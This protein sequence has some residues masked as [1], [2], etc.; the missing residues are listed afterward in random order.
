MSNAETKF[1]KS[2]YNI[3]FAISTVKISKMIFISTNY[4]YKYFE[5]VTFTYENTFSLLAVFGDI[6]MK[7]ICNNLTSVKSD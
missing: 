6:V 7:K 1:C 2:H 5:L 4:Y 3:F